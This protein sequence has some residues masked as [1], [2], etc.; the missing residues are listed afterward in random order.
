MIDEARIR[1]RE[2]RNERFADFVIVNLEFARL[3]AGE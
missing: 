2:F 1:K 3:D